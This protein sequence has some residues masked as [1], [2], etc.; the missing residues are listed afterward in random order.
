MGQDRAA[1][2][3]L[4]RN[5]SHLIEQILISGYLV[6][7]D[8][9]IRNFLEQLRAA[10]NRRAFDGVELHRLQR[11]FG[12]GDEEDVLHIV[13]LHGD[14]PVGSVIAYGCWNLESAR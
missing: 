2:E 8:I 11:A 12:F 7:F 6:I 10:V 3:V 9:V 5:C 4:F 13:F 1:E 14:S